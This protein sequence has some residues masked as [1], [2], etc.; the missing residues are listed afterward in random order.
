MDIAL[1]IIFVCLAG[2]FAYGSSHIVEEKKQGKTIPF[3]WEKK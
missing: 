1:G 2:I 3:P